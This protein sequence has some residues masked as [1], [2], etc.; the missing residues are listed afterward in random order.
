MYEHVLCDSLVGL[1]RL[2]IPV[3]TKSNKDYYYYYYSAIV[4]RKSAIYALKKESTN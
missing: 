1:D 2:L 4:H 3:V